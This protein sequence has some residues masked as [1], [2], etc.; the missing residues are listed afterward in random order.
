MRTFITKPGQHWAT[1]TAAG[2]VI[3]RLH[4]ALVDAHRHPLPPWKQRV[5]R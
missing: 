3:M 4:M 5:K 1:R 2:V